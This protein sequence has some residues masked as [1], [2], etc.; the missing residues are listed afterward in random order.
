MLYLTPGQFRAMNLGVD[1]T[2]FS[3]VQIASYLSRATE[4]VN[5]HCGVPSIP[6][7]HDFRGGTITGETHT[8]PVDPY[9]V[10]PQRRLFPYHKPVRNIISMRIYATA[11]Q[12][13]TFDAA[14]LYYEASEGWV[15]P[16][17]ANLTSYG[18]FGSAVLPF[19]GLS[20]PHA[21][22]DYSYGRRF[23]IA[24]QI[25]PD[26]IVANAWRATVGF[27]SSDAVTVTVNGVLRTTAYTI[28]RTE[29]TILFTSPFPAGSDTV[30]VTATGTL[31]PRI[32]IA[33]GITAADRIGQRNLL[34]AGFPAGVRSFRVAE[35]AVEKDM[36][37]RLAAGQAPPDTLPPEA[38]DL[39]SDLVIRPLAFG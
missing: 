8:W 36:P 39:I 17:S 7:P 2:G 20:E 4:A 9:R 28:N 3:D 30:E 5:E 37:R 12:Y 1:L 27:W 22:L 6:V 35:V 26:A 38:A 16:A 13:I 23:S 24:E 15:E 10:T 29:G 21:T 25:Y 19:V 32:A 34:A 11:T 14:E 18:L 31:L 33:T